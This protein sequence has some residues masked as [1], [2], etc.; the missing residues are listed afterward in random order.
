LVNDN[1]LRPRLHP[2]FHDTNYPF[3]RESF[4]I[5]PYSLRP[6]PPRHLPAHFHYPLKHFS[7]YRN[8]LNDIL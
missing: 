4:Q 6:N 1:E 2:V 8:L 3:L 5:E 7:Y